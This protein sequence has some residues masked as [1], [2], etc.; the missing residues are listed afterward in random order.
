M[1]KLVIDPEKAKEYREK[2]NIGE[3]IECT[4]CGDFC[5]VKRKF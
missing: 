5:S 2:S 3:H 4:M 1:F